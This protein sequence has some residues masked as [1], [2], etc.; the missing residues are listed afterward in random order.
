M[1]TAL[2]L[3]RITW[4]GRVLPGVTLC[5]AVALLADRLAPVEIAMTGRLLIDPVVLAILLGTS[6]RLVWRPGTAWEQGITC[7]AKFLLECSVVLLGVSIDVTTLSRLGL[8]TIISVGMLVVAAVA[9]SYA[10]GRACGLPVRLSVLVACGN[11]ICGNAAIGAVAPLIGAGARDIATAVSFTAVFG[12]LVVLALPALIPV[13]HLTLTQYGELAGLT[14]YSVP[15]VLAATLPVGTLSS[16]IGT[17]VKL[18]RVLMLG[19]VVL[20]IAGIVAGRKRRLLRRAPPQQEGQG[21]P[22]ISTPITTLV[23]W[24]LVGFVGL[25]SCRSSDVLPGVLIGPIASAAHLLTVVSMAGLGLT[26]DLRT[27]AQCGNRIALTVAGSLAGI[28][29]ISLMIVRSLPLP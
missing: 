12:L 11:S 24:F 18:L 4:L 19:P 14:V 17:I 7:S 26:V 22:R 6:V 28:F 13:L 27:L 15:Q 20:G 8:A 5:L 16:Q 2:P 1:T 9:G 10:F 25:A 23:P 29:L 21:A 3:N